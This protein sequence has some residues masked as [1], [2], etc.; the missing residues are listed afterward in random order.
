[1]LSFGSPLILFIV[2]WLGRDSGKLIN[3]S[4]EWRLSDLKHLKLGNRIDEEV[5]QMY[6]CDVTLSRD[7]LAV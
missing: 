6:H 1:M 3:G 2:K 4:G 5:G 7:S